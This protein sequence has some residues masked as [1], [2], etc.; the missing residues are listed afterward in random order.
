[1]TAS[2]SEGEEKRGKTECQGTPLK[3][4]QRKELAMAVLSD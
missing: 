1:M 4:R 2:G 3:D